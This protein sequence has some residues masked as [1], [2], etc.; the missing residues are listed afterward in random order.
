MTE[1]SKLV[2]YARK[3]ADEKVKLSLNVNALQ[4]CSNYTTSDGERYIALLIN[5]HRLQ[6]VMNGEAVVTTVSHN[7]E[8]I[9]DY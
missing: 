6:K 7:Q 1:K 2:G 5:K 3:T 8:I 9:S 4:D